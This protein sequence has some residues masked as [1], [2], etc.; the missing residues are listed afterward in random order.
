MSVPP[1]TGVTQ[2]EPEGRSR[3]S[4]S[5]EVTHWV[6]SQIDGLKVPLMTT[7]KRAHLACG[8]WHVAI[9]H[10]QAVVLLVGHELYGSALTMQRPLFEAYLRGM[11]LFYAASDNEVDA[12]GRD[13]FPND[14]NKLL[15]GLT[16]AGAGD[17]ADLKREWWSRMC[18]LTHTGF[19]QIG[20]RFTAEGLGPNYDP[21][22]IDK[23]LWWADGIA[24]MVVIALSNAA[25]DEPRA[26][27]ALEKMQSLTGNV[28]PSRTE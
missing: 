9:E 13:K 14:V 2:P 17:L 21:E 5:I 25:G 20:A 27:L 15:D 8:C 26:K 6:H 18:S 24:L 16:L 4:E 10:G 19:Q 3:L 7:S 28:G 22:E 23:A 12:A 11:W 1:G